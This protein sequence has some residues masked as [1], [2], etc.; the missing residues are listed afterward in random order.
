MMDLFSAKKVGIQCSECG[1]TCADFGHV[2]FVREG[3]SPFV[4]V[5]F[6]LSP[7][8]EAGRNGN[9]AGNF[10]PLVLENH[11]RFCTIKDEKAVQRWLEKE[12][13]RHM[14]IGG[15]T[16]W[17]MLSRAEV[18]AIADALS[19][20][21]TGRRFLD[22]SRIHRECLDERIKRNEDFALFPPSTG[23]DHESSIDVHLNVGIPSVED[24]ELNESAAA[25][26]IVSARSSCGSGLRLRPQDVELRRMAVLLN[27]SQ[28][29]LAEHFGVS[30]SAI[31]HR[32]AGARN[33]EWWSDFRSERTLRRKRARGRRW[34]NK[35]QIKEGAQ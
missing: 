14:N 11:V 34:R 30:Q 23:V 28:K 1:F 19:G 4:K 26:E 29:A 31:S 2:Y 12:T 35:K 18:M 21:I 6:S 33:R 9:Q 5:G 22:F 20:L 25:D 7:P 17:F 32:L 16:E 8:V 24:S 10:R 27:G 15:G 3:E 13:D